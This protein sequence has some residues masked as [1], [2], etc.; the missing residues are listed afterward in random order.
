MDKPV[1]YYGVL[2]HE[3]SFSQ[4]FD[5]MHESITCGMSKEQKEDIRNLVYKAYKEGYSDAL[6]RA[7]FMMRER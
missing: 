6:E 1:E 3:Q 2:Q 7:V 4:E 5:N